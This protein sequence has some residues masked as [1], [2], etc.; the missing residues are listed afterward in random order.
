MQMCGE[1]VKARVGASRTGGGCCA[2]KV[3]AFDGNLLLEAGLLTNNKSCE[4]LTGLRFVTAN[5]PVACVRC[6]GVWRSQYLGDVEC[7]SSRTKMLVLL[8]I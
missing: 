3:L 5:S 1:A 2:C 8:A 7:T 4:N 6:Y